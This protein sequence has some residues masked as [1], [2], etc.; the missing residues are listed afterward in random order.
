MLEG[1]FGLSIITTQDLSEQES[2]KLIEQLEGAELAKQNFINGSI[3]FEDFLNILELC[4]VDIDDYLITV[5]QN[6]VD[7]RFIL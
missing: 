7:A 2:F 3:S 4:E 5:E 6:L 1:I